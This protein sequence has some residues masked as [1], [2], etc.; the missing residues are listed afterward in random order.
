MKGLAGSHSFPEAGII[1]S[2]M[3]I[4]RATLKDIFDHQLTKIFNLIDGRLLSLEASS[5]NKQ[6]S[7]VILS[8]GLGSSPY[9][10]EEIKRRYEMNFGLRSSNTSSIRIMRVLEP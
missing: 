7:Y 2:R 9:L 10:Y 4:E 3:V 8:G 5:P 1:N 6:V